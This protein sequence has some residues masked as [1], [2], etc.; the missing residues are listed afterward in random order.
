MSNPAVRSMINN[1][2]EPVFCRQSGTECFHDLSQD[3]VENPSIN[4]NSLITAR[5]RKCSSSFE[6]DLRIHHLISDGRS[7][8][9]LGE[10]VANAYNGG[11]TNKEDSTYFEN[12]AH[13]DVPDFWK[14]YLSGYEPCSVDENRICGVVEGEAGY[15]TANLSFIEKLRTIRMTYDKEDVIVGTTIANR[16]AENMN[17]VG[18]FANTIPLRFSKEFIDFKEQLAYTVEQ[19]LSAMEYHTTPLAKI[20]EEM[21]KERDVESAPLFQ[22]VITFESTSINELPEMEG[23]TKSSFDASISNTF[24]TLLN[25]GILVIRNEEADIT[26]ELSK[27][28]P[29]ALLHM[30]PIVMNMF[31]ESDLKQLEDVEKWS[32]GGETI[33]TRTLKFMLNKGIRLIQL[34]GPTEATCYQ[35]LLDMKIGHKPTCVGPVIPNLSHGVML[36]SFSVVVKILQGDTLATSLVVFCLTHSERPQIEY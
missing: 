14:E 11:Q 24:G 23:F 6:F 33:S 1:G 17:T 25:G 29:I 35:T 19:I 4:D 36:D 5:L 32:F 31:D 18:L 2:K 13:N 27:H 30:T 28:Q 26:Q 8:A 20:I 22:Q 10:E 12:P 9:I 34:Y 7:L 3:N 16:T 15:V 21:V